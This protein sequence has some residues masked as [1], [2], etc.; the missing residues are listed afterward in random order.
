M[1]SQCSKS[2]RVNIAI[3]TIKI[4]LDISLSFKNTLISLAKE[5]FF[6]LPT[7]ETDMCKY[8]IFQNTYM[9]HNNKKIGNLLFNIIVALTGNLN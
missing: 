9:N 1:K 7:F 3:K 5:E 8:Q 6:F 2:T 4:T